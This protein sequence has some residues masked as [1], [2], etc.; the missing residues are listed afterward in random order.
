MSDPSNRWL[1]RFLAVG[2]CLAIAAVLLVAC[3]SAGPAARRP[4]RVLQMN[5]CDSGIARCYTGR[6]VPAA[7]AVIRA[8]APDVVTLDEV[9][10]DDVHA[11]DI[12]MESEAGRGGTVVA[13]F[14]AVENPSREGA[15]RCRNG[16]RYGIGILVRIPYHG[17]STYGGIYPAQDPNDTEERAWLC[18]DA[19]NELLACAT[20]LSNTSPAVALAQCH[21]LMDKAIPA[22]RPQTEPI[23]VG[24][25][26]NLR[27][28]GSP[29]VRSCVPPGF[30]R[31]DDGSVQQILASND[32]YT[33]R[34]DRSISMDGTTDHP[35][36][37]VGFSVAARRP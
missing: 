10:Q 37:L 4:L 11:L 25:D 26:F 1:A 24:G 2:A 7:E 15:F 8:N 16:Q 27:K 6:S 35:G 22:T 18:V 3:S 21:Y 30:T 5:L 31:A 23:V 12:A 9:C 34:S 29:D 33:T 17:Y 19:T 13:A 14:K 28:G 36:L 32:T 20:H